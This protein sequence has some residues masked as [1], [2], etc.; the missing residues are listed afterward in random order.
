MVRVYAHLINLCIKKK[1]RSKPFTKPRKQKAMPK[2]ENMSEVQEE[3]KSKRKQKWDDETIIAKGRELFSE[4]GFDLSMRDLARA[5]NTQASSLYRHVQSKRELWFAIT[6]RD[7]DDFGKGIQEIAMQHS[8]QPA[9]LLLRRIGEFFLEFARADFNRFK[10]MF[11]YEPPREESAGPFEQACQPDSLTSLIQV[12]Q[13]IIEQEKLINITSKQLAIM[14]YSQILGYSIIT[15]P[16]NDY[17]L[18]QKEFS[19]INDPAFD[20]FILDKLMETVLA[21]KQ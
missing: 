3:E 17:L 10:L 13:I 2:L 7:Y 15:S 4:K 16:I 8:N 18:Q 9:T 6:T 5:L 12:C 19:Y 1:I 14:V 21:H 11:L 20:K